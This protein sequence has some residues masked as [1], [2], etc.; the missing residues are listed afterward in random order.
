MCFLS[1]NLNLFH[2]VS[3]FLFSCAVNFH[4]RESWI[5]LP[6]LA[7]V[8]FPG[9]PYRM[10]TYILKICVCW[11]PSSNILKTLTL[12]WDSF[13]FE[14]KITI[15]CWL[16]VILE[17]PDSCHVSKLPVCMSYFPGSDSTS[18]TESTACNV[19]VGIQNKDL[20]YQLDSP[21]CEHVEGLTP[22]T[23]SC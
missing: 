19:F 21:M 12:G 16:L 20:A 6:A 9:L 17:T 8:A 11:R 14:Y 22:V 18:F 3:A 7:Q 15:V 4:V 2:N 10:S 1:Q 23:Y 13:G 5:S